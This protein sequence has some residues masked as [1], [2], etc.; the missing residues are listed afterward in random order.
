MA[1]AANNSAPEE[2][3]AIASAKLDE[4]QK[5]LTARSAAP[6]SAGEHAHFVYAAD[7]I[8]QFKKNPKEFKI[9]PPTEIPDG[10]PIGMDGAPLAPWFCDASR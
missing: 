10:P 3:R 9:A 2:V 7:Q 1:L 4:L 5:L 8:A 6:A